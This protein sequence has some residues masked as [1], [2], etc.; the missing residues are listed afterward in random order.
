MTTATSPRRCPIGLLAGGLFFALAG[1]TMTR[2]IDDRVTAYTYSTF[3]FSGNAYSQARKEC[4]AKAQRLS[5]VG[6]DC[7]FLLCTSKFDCSPE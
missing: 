1:C 5:H 6:T 3:D 4:E 7:G 2:Q